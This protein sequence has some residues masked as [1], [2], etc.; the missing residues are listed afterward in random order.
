MRGSMTYEDI[1]WNLNSEDKDIISDIIKENI[2]T[3]TKTRMPL[4]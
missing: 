2:E 1:F 4:L 3:T